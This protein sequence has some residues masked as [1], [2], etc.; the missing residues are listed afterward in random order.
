MTRRDL[1]DSIWMNKPPFTDGGITLRAA[2]GTPCQ[3][4][5]AEGIGMSQTTSASLLKNS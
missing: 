5:D 3:L 2:A 1:E 4:L